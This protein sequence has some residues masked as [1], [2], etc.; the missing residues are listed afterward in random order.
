MRKMTRSQHALN[1]NKVS[2][3]RNETEFQNLVADIG[4]IVPNHQS[5]NNSFMMIEVTDLDIKDK[6]L[7]Q[8]TRAQT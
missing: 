3:G 2:L 7:E 4:A 1:A 5:A 8:P 6:M